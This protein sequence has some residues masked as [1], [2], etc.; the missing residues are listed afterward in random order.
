MD[1]LERILA[2]N[3]PVTLTAP[4]TAPPSDSQYPLTPFKTLFSQPASFSLDVSDGFRKSCQHSQPSSSAVATSDHL[5]TRSKAPEYLE[6]CVNYGQ[7]QR[8]L[9][10]IDVSCLSNDGQVFE[11]MRKKY[12]E[13][14][15][16]KTSY[17]LEP[18]DV[19]YVR[20]RSQLHFFCPRATLCS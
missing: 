9:G 16:S 18:M 20:V 11:A 8:R 17:F 7:W 2:K 4:N 10:E 3:E 13:L 19:R 12:T 14:R 5:V 1:E 6:L 15:R